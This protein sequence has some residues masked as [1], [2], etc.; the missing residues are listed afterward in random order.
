MKRFLPFLR[1]SIFCTITLLICHETAFPAPDPILNK[2][3]PAG[4]QSDVVLT[5]KKWGRFS[6][7]AESREGTALQL[8]DRKV[9]LR[10][11]DGI[12]G[13]KNGRIDEFLDFGEY[14]I[15][16]TPHQ[17]GKSKT[18]LSVMPFRELNHKKPQYI[19]PLKEYKVSLRDF[20]QVSYWL[21][22]DRD[23]TVF[24]KALGRNV[25]DVQLWL[26]GEWRID[27]Q[28]AGIEAYPNVETP[29]KGYRIVQKLKAGFYRLTVYGGEVADWA[30]SSDE[31]PV[32]MRF[33]IPQ[34]PATGI[35]TVTISEKG[36]NEY[37]VA[38]TLTA[39]VMSRP[40]KKLSWLQIAEYPASSPFTRPGNIDSI[41]EKSADPRC[42]VH[43]PGSG[44]NGYL[45]EVSGV[46]G[47]TV[48]L[49]TFESI[50]NTIYPV[51]SG[52]Y[53]FSTI[54][55]G[56]PDDQI[57]PTGLLVHSSGKSRIIAGKVD[58][59]SDAKY[60][61]RTFNLLDEISM[62][63]R[64]DNSG[65]YDFIPGGTEMT[66]GIR[67][68]LMTNQHKLKDIKDVTGKTTVQL[69]KGYYRLSITPEK[70]GIATL[71]IA[72]NSMVR[73]I[74]NAVGMKARRDARCPN[75]QFPKL[76]LQEKEHYTFIYNSQAPE[77]TGSVFR[78]LPL[79]LDE[80]LPVYLEEGCE[81]TVP[82]R[83][84]EK[85]ILTVIDALGRTYPCK[86]NGTRRNTPCEISSG[87]IDLTLFADR[88]VFV[89]AGTTPVSR[90]PD[91]PP[92]QF[93]T[94][95]ESPLPRF[96][97]L[98]AGTPVYFDLE[99]NGTAVYE[100]TVAEA[101]MYRFEST[102]RLNTSVTLRDRFVVN[103]LSEKANGVGRN[104]RILTYLLPGTYQTQVGVHDRSTGHLGLSL[105]IN[106]TI[107]GGTL[108]TQ[109]EKRHEV[110]PGQGIAYTVA[111]TEEGEYE[112]I[113]QGQSGYYTVRLDDADGWPVVTP[114]SSGNISQKLSPGNYRF[115][116][117]PQPRK[118][119]RIA[120]LTRKTQPV[121]YEGKGPHRLVL[122]NPAGS[123]WMEESGGEKKGKRLPAV[124][125]VS[126]P[127][128]ARCR[129]TLTEGFTAAVC[130]GKHG[131]T[132]LT[133]KATMDTLLPMGT[134]NCL[135]LA[136]KQQNNAEYTIGIATE[137][138]MAGMHTPVS[139]DT[140]NI[141]LSAGKPGVFEL[142]SQGTA[143]V[144]AKLFKGKRLI[145]ANDDAPN[146]WNFRITKMLMPGTY[147]L[148][149]S[150]ASGGEV[151][152]TVRMAALADT[153]HPTWEC[154]TLRKMD[155]GGKLHRVPLRID[156]TADILHLAIGG[157]S[158]SGCQVQRIARDGTEQF[159]GASN[160]KSVALSIPVEPAN[161][162]AVYFWSVDHT[163]E[164][165]SVMI[166]TAAA[167]P[168]TLTKLRKGERFPRHF[169]G[170]RY[171][172][173]LKL[174][175]ESDSMG[176]FRVDADASFTGIKTAH[177]V[178][179]ACNYDFNGG[180][181]TLRRIRWVS[182]AFD[183]EGSRKLRLQHSDIS[184]PLRIPLERF[185]R[186]F[187][188]EN[189]AKTLS[190]L[191]AST[192]A[193]QPMCGIKAATVGAAEFFPRGIG[194]IAGVENA[195]GTVSGID[196][197]EDS[198]LFLVWDASPAN[199]GN[200]EKPDLEVVQRSIPL[201]KE[202]ALEFGSRI[203]NASAGTACRIP[204]KSSSPALV[205]VT[206]PR[207]GIAMWK[208][209]DGSRTT[210]TTGQ[211][212]QRCLFQESEG[213]LILVNPGSQAPFSLSC[214]ALDAAETRP[215]LSEAD[216][217]FQYE[218]YFANSGTSDIDIPGSAL[219]LKKARISFNGAVDRIDWWSSAGTVTPSLAPDAVLPMS[220][221]TPGV[222]TRGGK[223]TIHHS[224]GWIK[225]NLFKP[226]NPL[227]EWGGT[228]AGSNN[229][230]PLQ[231]SQAI[232]LQEGDNWFHIT[233]KT[234]T[235]LRLQVAAPVV[236]VVLEKGKVLTTVTA[237]RECDI[238]LPL[239]RSDYT[240]G[241]RGL[242]PTSLLHT[243]LLAT[244]LP[245][246]RLTQKDPPEVLLAAG[247]SRIFNFVLDKKSTIGIG[248][249][250]DNEVIMA[251]LLDNQLRKIHSGQQQY[252]ELD[253][254]EYFL[255][256]SIPR[257]E[258]PAQCTV[259]LAGQDVPPDEPPADVVDKFIR[260]R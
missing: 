45:L 27:C 121:S 257:N 256:L 246:L 79:S 160:G 170:N 200:S 122:N 123:V 32:F 176:H 75:L 23:T 201:E 99:R 110:L 237:I 11:R 34:L 242:G 120:R 231:H 165:V 158:I 147:T 26:N 148:K 224:T 217:V 52:D 205:T 193:G 169:D 210:F 178:N 155:L 101:G 89:N 245:L 137:T 141:T 190:L 13:E 53:W 208:R 216:G 179:T 211:V 8:I 227:G 239:R 252:L 40:K 7:L 74:K 186:P 189:E 138:L 129:L 258:R 194:V 71:K 73:M 78:K 81:V 220:N 29:L 259:R 135:V 92:K 172:S 175:M 46:P 143:D 85:S 30:R 184:T 185:P 221:V 223:F 243:R 253:K 154:N 59:I 60:L 232:A 233:P 96:P 212:V 240:I 66:I 213:E 51:T 68:L 41:H 33:A 15:V 228:L 114:L 235:H 36:Y 218:G 173:W 102:G 76:S 171:H 238:N 127:A 111:I 164:N 21:H 150:H 149:I 113:A 90:L 152:A 115:V 44:G 219:S 126:L 18:K 86:V 63:V 116:S 31:H 151:A 236:A 56:F 146:D 140:K 22:L 254:G 67:R 62:I 106:E 100:F 134:F 88:N 198:H 153:V 54:H 166:Q 183:D 128:P 163:D 199:G 180:F 19:T 161:R 226:G 225:I 17:D 157:T 91:A 197:P 64:I 230:R 20:E 214:I 77:L 191:T 58:T 104:A 156:S 84:T 112:L 192:K 65:K 16:A 55:S 83:V 94:G 206:I 4:R 131:D 117:V 98:L 144:A 38:S 145:A 48:T 42:I 103:A 181:C 204:Y 2:Q 12:P 14:K 109:K 203:W 130:R 97:E 167:V 136:D 50:G 248:L 177:A 125:V 222:V 10:K 247:E 195:S 37:Y 255:H 1:K 168:V 107:D 241:F 57:G 209:G 142:Y 249:A 251:S 118:T 124:Y 182:L 119:L 82:V 3:L 6:I 9:G 139:D 234:E 132:V 244:Y 187:H 35:N 133:W 43:T 105:D 25:A 70:K 80:A 159:C 196:L 202:P 260:L 229:I 24:I 72:K 87:Q 61:D 93:P 188:V 49:K 174:D 250:T 215:A 28:K 5:V 95:E 39:A 108:T 207:G 47:D 162:Y 69:D